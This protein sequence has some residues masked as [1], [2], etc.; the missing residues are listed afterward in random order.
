MSPEL[1]R[2]F[3][4]I[5]PFL[6]GEESPAQF[7]ERLGPSPSG[8]RRLAV[9]PRLV[10]LDWIGVIDKLYEATRHAIEAH[11]PGTWARLRAE[12]GR[13]H[14]PEHW[15][16]NDYGRPF[17]D[18]IAAKR[19]SG[20]NLP[21]F[22]EQLA[23]FEWL[24]F[25]TWTAADSAATTKV[26]PTLA[27]RQYSYAVPAFARAVRRGESPDPPAQ[28]PTTVAIYRRPDTLLVHVFYL[29]MAGLLVLALAAGE[30]TES[31]LARAGVTRDMRDAAENT[32]REHKILS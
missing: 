27:V 15:D 13:T 30:V 21:P 8:E 17:P 25:I 32:L 24:E 12:L 26:E 14:P 11:R 5:R 31:D 1:A 6:A 20:E 22:I 9:Y 3:D 19:E 23:D 29:S 10:S 28:K 2:F 16:I 7:V 18:W 4:A